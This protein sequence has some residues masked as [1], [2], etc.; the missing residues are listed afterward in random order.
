LRGIY[1]DRVGEGKAELLKE[2]AALDLYDVYRG[3]L[4]DTDTQRREPRNK[5]AAVGQAVLKPA[6]LCGETV[7]ETAGRGLLYRVLGSV[8]PNYS[9]QSVALRELLHD[10]SSDDTGGWRWSRDGGA[11]VFERCAYGD[12]KVLRLESRVPSFILHL[13]RGTG[14]T[15]ASVLSTLAAAAFA[16]AVFV[17]VLRWIVR[18]VTHRVLL[19]DL[20]P[21]LAKGDDGVLL[22]PLPPGRFW[23]H[24]KEDPG[25]VVDDPERFL[26]VRPGEIEGA[27]A[28]LEE[29]PSLSAVLEVP[30][31][32]ACLADTAD[33]ESVLDLLAQWEA[34]FPART[35]AV[36]A[37]WEPAELEASLAAAGNERWLARLREVTDTLT[38]IPIDRI[39]RLSGAED[40]GPRDG[41]IDRECTG[42]PVM[43]ELA[44]EL[45]PLR[46]STAWGRERRLGDEQLLEE[47]AER[48]EPHYQK[49][50]DGCSPEERLVLVQAAEEGLVNAK[51]RRAVRRLLALGL[52][53]QRPEPALM[54]ETFRRFVLGDARRNEV[55]ALEAGDSAWDRLR[56]PLMVVLLGS[57]VFVAVTQQ[58][59]FDT[60]IGL[61]GGVAA[62]IPVI[63][64][65]L[66]YVDPGRERPPAGSEQ[67]TS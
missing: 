4:F 22:P 58:D 29:D 51:D 36:V 2:R 30:E 56:W 1:D 59:F 13:T 52:L 24:R 35:L 21:P 34:R 67:E 20:V 10:G 31:L 9:D 47:L 8:L 49:L 63:I 17:L 6:E 40:G 61:L 26:K 54:N 45:E 46:S 16:L 23:L 32:A 3:F 44:R 57:L 11:I 41:V 7:A 15:V 18:F 33:A 53:R 28:K 19:V 39:P 55:T 66:A 5:T 42:D 65:L 12:G 38:V 50:W 25:A 48:A 64:R 37:S 43:S 14:G 27:L 60:T 62:A